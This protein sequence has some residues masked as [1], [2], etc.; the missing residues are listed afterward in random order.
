MIYL[1][2]SVSFSFKVSNCYCC[3]VTQ[4]TAASQ[5][6]LSFTISRS[7]LKLPAFPLSSFSFI[8]RPFSSS[9]LSAIRVVLS[10]YLSLIK[11][12]NFAYLF[13]EPALK[14]VVSLIFLF[15]FF[16]SLCFIYTYSNM[17]YFLLLITWIFFKN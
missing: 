6:S 11:F 3:S 5:A 4:W 8:K 13:K 1:L 9:S 2:G 10:A 14:L 16:F 15:V 12:I 17:C 7:L